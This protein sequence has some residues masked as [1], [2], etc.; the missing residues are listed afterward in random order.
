[1]NLSLC[2]GNIL[3]CDNLGAVYFVSVWS[4]ATLLSHNDL[5]EGFSVLFI[6]NALHLALTLRTVSETSS[7]QASVTYLRN[8]L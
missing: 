4:I 7:R 3:T 6:L 5:T 1:M 8:M 2:F